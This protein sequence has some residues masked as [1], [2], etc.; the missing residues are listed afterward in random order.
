MSVS[1]EFSHL[2]RETGRHTPINALRGVDLDAAIAI[3][4]ALK[5]NASVQAVLV[6]DGT[7][8]RAPA[9]GLVRRLKAGLLDWLEDV[10]LAR[11]RPASRQPRVAA[12]Q[13]APTI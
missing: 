7:G 10:Q 8:E 6:L 11:L 12:G 9:Q 3:S 2:N 4:M 13:A 5:D 1:V